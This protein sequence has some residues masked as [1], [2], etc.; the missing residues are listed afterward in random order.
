MK[1][2]QYLQQKY[3][4]NTYPNRQC[5]FIKGKG[6]Y[7]YS[8]EGE[9]Y[10]D[11]MTNYGVNILGYNHPKITKAL[12]RQL[13]K[14]ITLH[15]SFINDS[16]AE[17]SEMLVKR[18]GQSYIQVYWANSGAEAIEAA[19]KFAVIATKKRKFIVCEHG[20]HGKTLG[21]LSATAGEKYKKPFEP[22]LWEF[23]GIPFNDLQAL[24][25]TADDNTAAF[26]VEPVQGEGGI[27]PAKKEYLKKVREVCDKK[28]I[29]LIIDEIQTGVGRTGNFLASQKEHVSADILCLG[30]GLAGGIPVGATIINQ[31]VSI[32]IP[33]NIH[34]STFG[35][36]PLTCAGVIAT[37]EIVNDSLLKEVTEKGS[38][39]MKGLQSLKS[40]IVNE[41]RGEGLMIGVSIKDYRNKILKLLQDEKILTIPSGEDVVRFLPSYFIEKKHIDLVVQKMQKILKSM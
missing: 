11:M 24:E 29:L 14:L 8:Q 4:I 33:R 15:G 2:Y 36:N 20:Y 30:K 22:L 32:S 6:I 39:F 13:R 38:Y 25:K 27:I 16:R 18:C 26:I 1:D 34:T 37:V 40:E 35:G 19:L 7:L 21:A 28:N 17:A 10:L 5:T 31:K 23:H 3:M 9:R 12:I 41:V